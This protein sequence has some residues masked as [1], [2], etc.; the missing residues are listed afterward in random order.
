MISAGS[1]RP[2][3]TTMSAPNLRAAPNRESARSIATMW[4]GLNSCAVIIAASPIG[5]AP[6]GVVSERNPHILGLS[7]VDEMAEN[8]TAAAQALPVAAVAAVSAATARGDTRHQD[9]IA[10]GQLLHRPR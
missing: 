8:P 10:D 1:S 5:P 3:L 9:P 7:A 2:L 4:L 6:R